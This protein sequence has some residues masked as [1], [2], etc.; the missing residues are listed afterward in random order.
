M[1]PRIAILADFPI[2]AL[3]DFEIAF[4]AQNHCPTGLL[5]MAAAMARKEVE[6]HWITLH[7]SVERPLRV[8]R[9]NQFFYCLPTA[10][11]W[12][13]ATLFR[14]DRR[15]IGECLSEIGPD[16]VHAW[17]CE[18]VYGIAA[19][20]SG[21]RNILSIQG[22]L[23]H[24]A[25]RGRLAAR[26]YVM[27]ALEW[28]CLRK[29]GWI[30]AESE[31][32]CE[33]IRR[34]APGGRIRRVDYGVREDFYAQPWKPDP[35]APTA[36]FLGTLV[37]RKGIQDLVAAFARPELADF[38]L[39]VIGSGGS[40]AEALRAR[41]TPNIRWLGRVSQEETLQEMS[42]AWLLA[43]PTR[44]D[45]GPM[46]VKE[47]RVMGL[48]VVSTPCGGTRDYITDGKNGYLVA[49]G[50]I[51]SLIDKLGALLSDFE[52]CR[53]MGAYQH[54]EQRTFF[55]PRNTAQGFLSLYQEILA[56]SACCPPPISFPSG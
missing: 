21:Y 11:R 12:R 46:V 47:A 35:K 41:A 36:L 22:L 38:E 28:Y 7:E 5:P 56:G 16:L 2:Q 42:R 20:N 14:A 26:E 43:L 24:Y 37:P 19:V 34:R 39:R 54:E 55:D 33:H 15:A 40:W 32:A 4:R 1:K 29:A 10:R 27:A 13:A 51:G 25:L 3:P 49:L 48:P 6:C 44:A 53:R 45:T 52:K 9:E 17:G 31:W 18:D 23:S 8:R 50:D 30:T